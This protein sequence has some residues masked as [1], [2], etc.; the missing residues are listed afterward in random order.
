MKT[1]ISLALC[2]LLS[3]AQ[4]LVTLPDF[5]L[6][7]III[8]TLPPISTQPDEIRI[9]PFPFPIFPIDPLP[10]EPTCDLRLDGQ[11]SFELANQEAPSVNII[12]ASPDYSLEGCNVYSGG[13]TNISGTSLSFTPALQSTRRACFIDFDREHLSALQAV[14][15]QVQAQGGAI[16]K[17]FDSELSDIGTLRR[18]I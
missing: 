13:R 10:T 14:A 4:N 12:F 3:S 9:Q 17:L 2:A 8:P 7:D 6:E 1:A 15:F 11:Y 18:T 5:N 16:V